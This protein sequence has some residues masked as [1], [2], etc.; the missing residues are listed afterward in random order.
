MSILR[1]VTIGEGTRRGFSGAVPMAMVVR[2][3]QSGR[4]YW[5]IELSTKHMGFANNGE[6]ATERAATRASERAW[7]RWIEAA[8]LT[9][10]SQNSPRMAK[11]EVAAPAARKRKAKSA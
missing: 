9:L 8:A 2:R 6:V 3:N 11:V 10:P 5:Q 1:W 4:F 7:A